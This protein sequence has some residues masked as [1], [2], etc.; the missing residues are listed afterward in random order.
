MYKNHIDGIHELWEGRGRITGITLCVDATQ[1]RTR[2]LSLVTAYCADHKPQVIDVI[3]TG[4]NKSSNGEVDPFYLALRIQEHLKTL[5]RVSLVTID[6]LSDVKA[7]KDHLESLQNGPFVVPGISMPLR[8]MFNSFAQ[9]EECQFLSVLCLDLHDALVGEKAH[10]K[11]RKFFYSRAI[12]L[13]EE[14][15]K[16]K[17]VTLLKPSERNGEGADLFFAMHRIVWLRPAIRDTLSGHE[18]RSLSDAEKV[19]SDGALTCLQ[20]ES[21]YEA[22]TVIV[23]VLHPALLLMEQVLNGT[24]M[25]DTLYYHCRRASLSIASGKA[26]LDG[27]S[28]FG[29]PAARSAGYGFHSD[30]E[31]ISSTANRSETS[32]ETVTGKKDQCSSSAQ[33]DETKRPAVKE[34][35]EDN[36]ARAAPLDDSQSESIPGTT[37]QQLPGSDSQMMKSKTNDKPVRFGDVLSRGWER[38][39]QLLKSDFALAGESFRNPFSSPSPW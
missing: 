6:G 22:L 38:C 29:E 32:G 16:R 36:E 35:S 23:T 13:L 28:F 21:F 15:S 11:V 33:P 34:G 39:S 20:L 24:P 17:S 5:D 25:M 30:G 10:P 27:L 3:A 18:F 14:D 1:S 31:V 12:L 8:S 37:P 9:T 19:I 4:K 26:R 7:A 2:S